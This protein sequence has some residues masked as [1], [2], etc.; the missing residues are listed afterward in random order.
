[1]RESN[2]YSFDGFALIKITNPDET[3]FK[4]FGSS[5]GGY[6]DGDVWRVN[7]GVVK[8][9]VNDTHYAFIGHTGSCYVA[10]KAGGHISIYNHSV[11]DNFLQ[12][13]GVCLVENKDIEKELLEHG[14][15]VEV[16]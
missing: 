3:Y 11:L 5:S 15:E 4:V 16:V 7:S 13:E 9:L 2:T 12:E 10:P 6:L 14:I 1:M 8:V